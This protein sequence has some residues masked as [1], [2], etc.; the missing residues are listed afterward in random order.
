[1]NHT[2]ECGYR[3][4]STFFNGR[5]K[6]ISYCP[7]PGCGAKLVTT[8]ARQVGFQLIGGSRAGKSVFLASLFH[9]YLEKLH[10]CKKIRVTITPDYKPYFDELE[11]WYQG[12]DTPPTNDKNSQMYPILLDGVGDTKRQFSIYDVAGELF[13]A[14]STRGNVVQEQFSYCDGLI[15]VLD[16]FSDGGLRRSRQQAGEALGDFSMTH[17]DEVAS[18]FI[19]YMVEIGK[20]KPGQRSNIPMAVLIVKSDARE[21]KS[22]IGPAK[23]NLLV[24]QGKY[25]SLM[26]ARDKESRQFLTDIGLGGVIGILEMQ[27]TNLHYFPVSAMGHSPDGDPYEPWGVMEVLDWLI[28]LADEELARAMKM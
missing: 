10:S 24:R 21:V 18:N 3:L 20:A 13:A 12:G 16:P 2:C 17:P 1:M 23:I 28:P 6:L 11:S 4:P 15:F 25:S 19:N 5:S 27:F 22:V 9:Q 7:I 8:G 14:G 26:E